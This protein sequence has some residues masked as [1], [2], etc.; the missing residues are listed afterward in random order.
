[1]NEEY[2]KR[3][4]TILTYIDNNLSG[5]LSLE[6][7]APL[8]F[9]S[10]FHFHLLFKMVTNETLN[11]YVTRKKIEKAASILMHKNEITIR[12]CLVITFESFSG[13]PTNQPFG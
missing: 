2:I 4:N 9:Y 3:I 7:I 12:F 8:A 1:M 10:P 11:G 5:D 6:T 13:G